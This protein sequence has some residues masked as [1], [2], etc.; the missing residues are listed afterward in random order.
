MPSAPAKKPV[1]AKP[2]AKTA[3]KAAAK[4]AA[5]PAGEKAPRAEA[6][7]PTAGAIL[8]TR[9]LVARVCEATGAK[10]KDAR[11]TVE[12]TLA[13]LGK[14]LD[15]GELLNLPPLGAVRIT[16][17][18]AEGGDGPMKLK[19]R[20]GAGTAGGKKDDKEALAAPGEAS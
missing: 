9:D 4:P 11:A 16:P 3:A 19:L 17:A 12:A 18:K 2:A 1:A 13:E 20:R 15:A 7:K 10:I 8:R 5:K 6:S 14:S